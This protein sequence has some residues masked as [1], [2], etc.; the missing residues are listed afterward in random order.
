MKKFL[1]ISLAVSSALL[2]ESFTSMESVKVTRSEPV[3]KT[4]TTQKP[5]RE[6]WEESEQ[7]VSQG[8]ND[9]IG[10]L[11]GGAI[12]G[13]LGS[14]MGKGTGKTAATIGG[15]IA[16]AMIGQGANRG[17]TDGSVRTV[18]KCKTRYESSTT[19]VLTGYN[20]FSVYQGKQIVK[21]SEHPQE[22]IT[23]YTNVS[24]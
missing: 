4:I 19:Q 8:G 11:V 13:A 18:E 7:S 1:L 15:A 2:A 5:I 3:Y 14:Q 12:G 17:G 20:N 22:H 23:I 16:G 10:G 24:Y 6:C 21:F 9:V